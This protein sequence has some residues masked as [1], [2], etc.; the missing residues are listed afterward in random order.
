MARE[1]LP[2]ASSYYGCENMPF[3]VDPPTHSQ[4]ERAATQTYMCLEAY[5]AVMNKT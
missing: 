3:V 2:L 5:K 4:A 1:P